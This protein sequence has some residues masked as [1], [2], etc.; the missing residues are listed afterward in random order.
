MELILYMQELMLSCSKNQPNYNRY[1]ERE[2][3]VMRF[4]VVLEKA[5]E[6]G[7]NA[8]VPALDGCYSEG[9]TIEDALCNIREAIQCYLE[10]LEKVNEK[11]ASSRQLIRSIEVSF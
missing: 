7:Y 4:K 6:G 11:K 1:N 2:G 8:M 3:V 5:D 10:G 9:E